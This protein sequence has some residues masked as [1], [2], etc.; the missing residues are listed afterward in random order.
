MISLEVRKL[1]VAAHDNGMKIQEIL[2]TFQVKK[3]AVYN[4]FQLVKETG[5]VEPRPHAYGRKPALNSEG[6]MR[7]EQLIDAQPDI[8]FQE[9][10]DQMNL[11]ISIPAISKIISG[12]L[13]YRYKK[14]RYMPANANVRTYKRGESYG[15]SNSQT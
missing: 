6:L 7:M 13:H 9:I 3:T 10:K 4:L 14:R 2:K 11:Q 12:K 8:T 1:I 15:K 5:S